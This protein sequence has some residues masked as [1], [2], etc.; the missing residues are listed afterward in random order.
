[1]KQPNIKCQ[2]CG[3]QAF[4]RP[5]SVLNKAEK[6]DAQAMFYVCARYP[7]CDAYVTAHAGNLMPMGT[8]ANRRLRQKRRAAHLAFNRLWQ[9]NI[10]TRK[11]AYRWLQTQLGIASEDAHIARFLDYRCEETI[12]LCKKFMGKCHP[13]EPI[14]PK[15]T[16][17]GGTKNEKPAACDARMSEA[18]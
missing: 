10:M 5:A 14:N 4:L 13:A 8:L 18:C 7:V 16:E 2:Y 15:S 6:A 11:E 12:R 9:S 3:S 1:M 17:G